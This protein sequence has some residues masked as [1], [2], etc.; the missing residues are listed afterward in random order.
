MY[1]LS[2]RSI[3]LAL[4]WVL[5]DLRGSGRRSDQILQFVVAEAMAATSS[6][7]SKDVLAARV[8]AGIEEAGRVP[9]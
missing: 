5:C 6:N 9:I 1:L 7:R 8:N 4:C 3:D 2:P